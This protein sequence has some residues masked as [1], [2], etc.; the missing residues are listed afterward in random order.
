MRCLATGSW[1]S[2]L[3]MKEELLN[4]AEKERNMTLAL[5]GI[6]LYPTGMP[7]IKRPYL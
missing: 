5:F 1:V 4:L 2:F 7:H 6:M 3:A